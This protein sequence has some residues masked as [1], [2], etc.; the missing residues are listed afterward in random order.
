[1]HIV[2]GAILVLINT[3]LFTLTIGVK[4]DPTEKYANFDMYTER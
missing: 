4:R 2:Q 1:M 3:I